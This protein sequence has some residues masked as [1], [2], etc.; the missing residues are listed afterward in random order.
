MIPER[1]LREDKSPAGSQVQSNCT[2][3]L[4]THSLQEV[5]HASTTKPRQLDLCC[6]ESS[7]EMWVCLLFILQARALAKEG[8]VC[9]YAELS[10]D[11]TLTGLWSF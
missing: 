10:P 2:Y 3:T 4:R 11:L 5:L 1:V 9:I 8:K 6:V 7:G